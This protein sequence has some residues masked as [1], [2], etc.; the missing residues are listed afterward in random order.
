MSS[1]ASPSDGEAPYFVAVGASGA[2]GLDDLYDLLG[3]LR[4]DLAA[5]VLVV[6]HRPS[7]RLSHLRPLLQRRSGLPINV[8]HEADAFRPGVCYIGE[9]ASHLSLAA[10]SRVHLVQGAN[11]VYRNRTVDLLFTSVA[12][13]AKARGIGVVL[14]GSLSDGSRGLAAIHYAGGVTMVLGAGGRA[15]PGM[16]R[17]ATDYDGPIDFT[18]SAR[19]IAG[20][21]V[22]RVTGA[23][24]SVAA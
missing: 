6:L 20:A 13:H 18:G 21:I 19:E 12:D 2:E 5:V 15:E 22:R 9:P 3:A 7:D 17:N 10:R 4:P 8:P 1:P 23:S 16:P 11:D 24:P 14:R